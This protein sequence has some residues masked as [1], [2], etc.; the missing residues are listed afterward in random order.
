M[1]LVLA[2]AGSLVHSHLPLVVHAAVI[3]VVI[4]FRY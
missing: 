2:R 3:S 1:G 4:A